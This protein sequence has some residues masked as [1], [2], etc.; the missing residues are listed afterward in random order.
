VCT[1]EAG[2][3]MFWLVKK[4]QLIKQLSSFL[5]T[6]CLLKHDLGDAE[7]IISVSFMVAFQIQQGRNVNTK[8]MG[9]IIT[10]SLHV[11]KWNVTF[12]I[13]CLL[14]QAS[15]TTTCMGHQLHPLGT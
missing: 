9:E 4:Q 8:W 1:S 11:N 10:L 6:H 7:Y 3:M 13:T 15:T 12:R 5:M 2:A 14:R